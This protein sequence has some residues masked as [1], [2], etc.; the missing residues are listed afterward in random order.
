MVEPI[1]CPLWVSNDDRFRS[2]HYHAWDRPCGLCGRKVVVSD[3]IKR[4]LQSNSG[5]VVVCEQCALAR[6]SEIEAFYRPGTETVDPPEACSICASL[7]EQE[8]CAA[9]ELARVMGLPDSAD[10]QR[11]WEHLFNARWAHQFKAHNWE[12]RGRK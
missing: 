5:A 11:K 7:K 12:A 10:V 9:L 1:I 3:A 6:F 4:R 2:R 8:E